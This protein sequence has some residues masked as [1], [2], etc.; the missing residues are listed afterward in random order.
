MSVTSLAT[1]SHIN[2]PQFTS[3]FNAPGY[4]DTS[5]QLSATFFYFFINSLTHYS[6]PASVC[7]AVCVC[8]CYDVL[9]FQWRVCVCW[10]WVMWLWASSWALPCYLSLCLFASLSVVCSVLS[11]TLFDCYQTSVL[12]EEKV[13]VY[14][15]SVSVFLKNQTS[16]RKSQF[17][18]NTHIL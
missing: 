14:M 13:C 8:V 5:L 11:S 10:E 7:G 15:S 17:G 9:L 3:V 6:L 12:F 2:N 16:N 4:T 1:L 18:T